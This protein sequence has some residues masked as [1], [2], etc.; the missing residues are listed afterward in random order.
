MA[1]VHSGQ[2][3]TSGWV[4]LAGFGSWEH[5]YHMEQFQ[6]QLSAVTLAGN[7]CEKVFRQAILVCQ[8]L[9]YY[10]HSVLVLHLRVM[11]SNTQNIPPVECL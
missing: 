4:L 2:P 5:F 11:I 1:S 9:S 8:E 3:S 6:S 7:L 10:F